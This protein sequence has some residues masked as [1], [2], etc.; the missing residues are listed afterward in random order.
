M[1]SCLVP[2]CKPALRSRSHGLNNINLL[3]I[4]FAEVGMHKAKLV[5]QE[6]FITASE[7]D[8]LS[9]GWYQL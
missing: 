2:R 4:R 9:T 3:T 7:M 8:G 6:R 5:R 1:I